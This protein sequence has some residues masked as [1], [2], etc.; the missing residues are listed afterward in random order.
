MGRYTSV[1]PRWFHILIVALAFAT[2][3]GLPEAVAAVVD[4]CA[5]GGAAACGDEEGVGCPPFCH[6][7]LCRPIVG[8]ATPLAGVTLP[9]GE[10]QLIS[11]P[12]AELTLPT[13]PSRGVFHPPRQS[14]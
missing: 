8:P 6:D 11:V 12:L 7:C 9:R 2:S 13:P 10:P 14:A 4:E 3:T 1:V 5:D